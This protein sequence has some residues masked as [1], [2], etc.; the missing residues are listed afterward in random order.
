MSPPTL[1]PQQ[2]ESLARLKDRGWIPILTSLQY[3]MGEGRNGVGCVM[4]ECKTASGSQ[5]V[6]F[7]I[8]PDGY[9]HS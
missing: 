2:T 5:Q 8:E 1:T 4:V 9:A 6:W 7:G 3:L